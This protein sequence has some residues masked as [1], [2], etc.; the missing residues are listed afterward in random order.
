MVP[1]SPDVHASMSH[2]EWDVLPS[3]TIN[4]AYSR[5]E[6]VDL[7]R[8]ASGANRTTDK[9][10]GRPRIVEHFLKSVRIVSVAGPLDPE[11]HL[12]QSH[13][14]RPEFLAAPRGRSMTSMPRPIRA[15]LGRNT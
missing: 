1:G 12:L 13:D 6:P 7:I 9:T 4:P 3:D 11:I 8:L 15:T 14:R 10:G 5:V 2:G